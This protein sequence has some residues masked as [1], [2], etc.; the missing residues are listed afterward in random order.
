MS[1]FKI[2]VSV[3]LDDGELNDKLGELEKDHK[4]PVSLDMK[5]IN[6]QLKGLKKSFQDAFKLD[7]NFAN[8]LN[9]IAKAMDKINSGGGG[10]PS[11]PKQQISSLVSEYKDMNNTIEKLQKQLNKGGLGEESITR[12]R[13]QIA[14]MSSELNNLYS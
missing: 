2:K 9:K 3:Q 13:N 14:K 1:E 11:K 8:D 10:S 7:S 5:K 4:I 12:T 6:S